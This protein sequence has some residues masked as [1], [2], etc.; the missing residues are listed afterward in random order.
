[1]NNS[2]QNLFYFDSVL[3][4]SVKTPFNLGCFND[5]EDHD[6]SGYM[7]DL[8]GMTVELCTDICKSLGFLYAGA[9]SGHWCT[10]GNSFGRHGSCDPST[11]TMPCPG[12][13]QQMCG[14]P[15]RQYIYYLGL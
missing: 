8:P 1:M 2:N 13:R 14:G 10:C 11:C 5:E 9:Q 6:M 3:L 15:W 12:N 4:F 7:I